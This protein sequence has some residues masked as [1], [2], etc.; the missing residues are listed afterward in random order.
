MPKMRVNI[1]DA[2]HVRTLLSVVADVDGD[3]VLD[4]VHTGAASVYF[5]CAE[6]DIER[7]AAIL[8]KKQR[9]SRI[10]GMRK[11]CEKGEFSRLMDRAAESDSARFNFYPRTFSLP[12]DKVPD[13]VWRHGR[14]LIFKPDKGAQGEGIHLIPSK[15]ELTR[16]LSTTNGTGVLQEYLA[17]PL[18]LPGGLQ[19]GHAR[20]R[21]D[22]ESP[23]PT[24]VPVRG[25]DR[26]S[27]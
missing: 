16:R 24:C 19:V 27:V 12:E 14:M 6:E 8:K 10:P 26:A 2:R 3:F 4:P 1:S 18:L 20:L 13:S 17:K 21:G 7:R 11:S 9:L 23:A 5:V 25:R 22:P 15:D